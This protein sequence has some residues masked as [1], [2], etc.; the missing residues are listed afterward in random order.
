CRDVYKVRYED[1][2]ERD[3]HYSKLKFFGF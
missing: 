3:Q 1:N 2:E